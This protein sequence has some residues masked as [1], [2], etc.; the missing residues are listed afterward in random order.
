MKL[1]KRIPDEVKLLWEFKEE[2]GMTFDQL[3]EE[4]GVTRAILFRWFKGKTTPNKL[5]RRAIKT[6]LVYR[7]RL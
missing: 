7:D 1:N 6:F 2:S 4:I 3:S 5:S